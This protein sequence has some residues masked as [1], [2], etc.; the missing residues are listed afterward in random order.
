MP[1]RVALY[2]RV[3]TQQQVHTQTSAQQLE[4]LQAHCVAQHWTWSPALVF[5]DDGYSGATL[6]RPGLERLRDLVAEGAVDHVVITTPDRLARK[7][8]HQLLLIEEFEQRGCQ[9]DFLDRPMG[10]DPNDQLL[11]HIRGAVAEY[12]RTLIAERLRRG[13]QQKYR[14]GLL[15]PWTTPPYGYRSAPDHPRTPAAVYVAPSEG[16]IVTEIFA[17]Y[18]EPGG[19]VAGVA[20]WLSWAGIPSPTGKRYW[21]GASVRRILGN[22]VYRGDVYAGKGQV[23]PIAKRRSALAPV[24]RRSAALGPR[25]PEEWVF[26]GHVPAIVSAEQFAQVQQKL[27]SNQQRACRNNTAHAYLLRGLVSCGLC[28]MACTGQTRRGYAYYV[29]TGRGHPVVTG[30]DERCHARLIPVRELEAA[31]WTDLCA[32]LTQ[33]EGIAWAL[34]R[35]QSGAWDPQELQARRETLRQAE[36]GLTAQIERLTTAYLEQII[37]LDEYRRRRH[38]LD[39]RAEALT[40]QL[41]GLEA[42]A[43]QQRE[44]A[45]AL[46]HIAAFSQ[47]VTQGLEAATFAQKRALVE[48]LI[49]RVVVTEDD[50]EIRYVIPTTERS[51]HTRFYQLR[52]AYCGEFPGQVPRR[53]PQRGDLLARA[54]C[55]G[56]RRALATAVQRGATAQRPGLPDPSGGGGDGPGRGRRGGGSISVGPRLTFPVDQISGAPHHNAFSC[57]SLSITSRARST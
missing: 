47:R 14:A 31:V 37:G 40:Q 27:S 42:Q 21:T 13:R 36:Q 50:V 46:A 5:R 8:L 15:L 19:S 7:Y 18:L 33:P 32:L 48:L 24:G 41:Q 26:V 9:V 51:E 22:P 28:R 1:Q 29:C 23:R 10:H 17:R 30:R 16:A 2:A 34:E 44:L 49:D 35:G 6:R 57:S 25:A 12:E 38:E 43:A 52:L 3:S 56:G 39:E 54:T 11:L 55:A 4:R 53:M 20:K 45:P